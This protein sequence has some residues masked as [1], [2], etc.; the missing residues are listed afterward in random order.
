LYSVDLEDPSHDAAMRIGSEAPWGGP[1]LSLGIKAMVV[2]R[3]T[4]TSDH[5]G[6]ASPSDGTPN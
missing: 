3:V 2:A 1:I 5:L 6:V 4:A